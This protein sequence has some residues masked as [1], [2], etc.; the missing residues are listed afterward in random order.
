M[1]KKKSS[2]KKSG[3]VKPLLA[4][5]AIGATGVAIYTLLKNSGLLEVL[6]E[7][8]KQ[9]FLN[10]EQNDKLHN[11]TMKVSEL[12]AAQLA[13]QSVPVQSI[14][15]PITPVTSQA[16][17]VQPQP[18]IIQNTAPSSVQPQP[19]IVHAQPAAN[20]MLNPVSA[21]PLSAQNT[22]TD[23]QGPSQIPQQIPSLSQSQ[24]QQ[25]SIPGPSPKV[26]TPT[27]G[28]SPLPGHRNFFGTFSP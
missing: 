6:K 20:Q 26:N 25:N 16:L 1:T 3:I 4:A 13:S 12:Q 18:I 17:P 19:I 24:Q 2:E 21:T 22:Q 10:S 27:Q 15:Q 8:L 11:L 14:P 9:Q 23:Q 28:P 7:K 5:G